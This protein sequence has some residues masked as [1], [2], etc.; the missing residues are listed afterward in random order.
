MPLANE[1][2]PFKGRNGRTRF[3]GSVRDAA[4]EPEPA[5]EPADDLPPIS[6]VV[7]RRPPGRRA[8]R[9]P[10]PASVV[11]PVPVEQPAPQPQVPAF[12]VRRRG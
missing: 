6:E 3:V 8:K 5:E 4:A 10:E 11:Q 12:N 1:Q 7:E 2:G 9:T